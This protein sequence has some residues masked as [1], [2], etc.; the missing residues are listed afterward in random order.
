MLGQK[1]E[2]TKER[3]ETRTNPGL[4]CLKHNPAL[5]RL[6]E[7]NYKELESSLNYR[8]SW[9]PALATGTLVLEVKGG[10]GGS[11]QAGLLCYSFGTPT[12]HPD[13]PQ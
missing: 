13:R 11:G 4:R 8:V 12:H 5:E 9:W 7:E 2:L 1:V 3:R 6:R 10:E